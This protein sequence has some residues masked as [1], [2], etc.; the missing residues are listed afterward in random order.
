MAIV[1]IDEGYLPYI[2][3]RRWI[4][5]SDGCGALQKSQDISGA[6]A[7]PN[8][9]EP[10]STKLDIRATGEAHQYPKHERSNTGR[11]ASS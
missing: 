8:G 2:C 4:L 9:N 11:L 5:G 6:L 1:E 3:I 10:V 7:T